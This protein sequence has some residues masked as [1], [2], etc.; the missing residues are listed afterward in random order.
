MANARALVALV[1]LTLTSA[2]GAKPRQAEPP[3]LTASATVPLLVEGNRPFIDVTFHKADG[4]IKSA[5]FLVDSGG[6]AFL[7]VEPLAREL[8][9]TLGA[10]QSEEGQ[11][12]AAVTSPVNASVGTMPLELNPDRVFAMIGKDNMLSPAAPGHA[13]GMLPGHVLAHYQVVFDYPKGTF[14]IAKAGT[15]QP[16]GSPLPMPVSASSGFP[17][18]EIQ[19]DGVTHGVLLDT[20]ASFTMVSEALLKSWGDAHPDWQRHPG[21]FG[22]AATLGGMTLETMFLP[23]VTWGTGTLPEV[24]VVSQREGV[25][26]KRMSSMMSQPI[27]GSLAGNVLKHFRVELDYPNQKL[28]LSGPT[29]TASAASSTRSPM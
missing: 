17:R 29:A 24:G 25:F 20:G 18:T 19:V 26:E 11:A 5:R 2:C 9:L 23:R 6:G 12:F 21:A 16:E 3:H 22:E 13:D 1:A 10:S 15:L 14:T 4:S 27:V 8:G 7:L 28:Y